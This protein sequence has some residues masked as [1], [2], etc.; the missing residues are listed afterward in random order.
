MRFTKRF[1]GLAA[2]TAFLLA[3]P[4][5]H[6][7]DTSSCGLPES[8]DCNTDNGS[9][10]CADEACCLAVCELDLFCCKEIWMA[11]GSLKTVANL[12]PK[13]NKK[14]TNDEKLRVLSH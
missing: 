6:A 5:V 3:A 8:G 4:L 1:T 10:G 9:P 14:T 12:M 2:A 7:D 13:T 11:K